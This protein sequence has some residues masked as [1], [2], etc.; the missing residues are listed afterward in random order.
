M[1]D[2]LMCQR[3]KTSE[4]VDNTINIFCHFIDCQKNS[5]I[6]FYFFNFYFRHSFNYEMTGWL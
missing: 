5:N 2:R 1:V 4:T 6:S 3:S